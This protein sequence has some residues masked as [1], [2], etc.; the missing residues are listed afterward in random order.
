MRFYLDGTVF[1]LFQVVAAA[2]AD[3]APGRATGHLAKASASKS[4][5][6][7]LGSPGGTPPG[8][9]GVAKSN[10]PLYPKVAHVH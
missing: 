8:K 10:R 6:L 7:L 1:R 5:G 2:V 9:P 3:V 4:I